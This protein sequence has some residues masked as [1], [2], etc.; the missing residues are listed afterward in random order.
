MFIFHQEN[1]TRQECLNRLN[2]NPDKYMWAAFKNFQGRLK[3]DKAYC[4]TGELVKEILDGNISNEG[5]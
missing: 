3:P 1:N 5:T 2:E 4:V